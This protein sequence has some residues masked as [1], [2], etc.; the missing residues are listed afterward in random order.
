MFY[1]Y[2][3]MV[4]LAVVLVLWVVIALHDDTAPS[5]RKDERRDT[6]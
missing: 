2:T 6:E 4:T 3:Y 1:Y 5:R